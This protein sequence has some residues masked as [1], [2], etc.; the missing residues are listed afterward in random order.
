MKRILFLAFFISLIVFLM[1]LSLFVYYFTPITESSFQATARVTKDLD[2]FDVNSS[3]LTF[4]SFAI[5]GSS[6]RSI[7]VNNSYSFPVRLE[8]V[9][10]GSISQL[11]VYS[12]LTIQPYTT[13][14]FKITV[15]APLNATL[16]N[17]TGNIS[18]RLLH[19]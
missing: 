18:V 1:S 16:G 15:S 5:G 17:Y 9:A 3:A 13:S 4:G 12:P 7:L 10:E 2:G 14:S 6:T 19:A 8:P 11:I